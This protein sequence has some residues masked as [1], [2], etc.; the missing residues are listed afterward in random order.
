MSGVMVADLT[1]LEGSKYDSG[2]N[3]RYN[4]AYIKGHSY[5]DYD[6]QNDP[7]KTIWGELGKGNPMYKN[8]ME[9]LGSRSGRI[10]ATMPQTRPTR[11][12]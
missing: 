4:W 7:D 12:S 5:S 10:S 8:H 11:P 9:R 1:G 2:I 6:E 3:Q